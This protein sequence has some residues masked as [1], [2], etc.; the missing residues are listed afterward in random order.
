MKKRNVDSIY[1]LPNQPFPSQKDH[2]PEGEATMREAI[3]SKNRTYQ[4]GMRGSYVYW[5]VQGDTDLVRRAEQ[6]ARYIAEFDLTREEQAS[7]GQS[8][9]QLDERRAQPKPPPKPVDPYW[10]LWGRLKSQNRRSK[11][12]E[13]SDDM[14]AGGG[15]RYKCAVAAQDEV[16]AEEYHLPVTGLSVSYNGEDIVVSAPN[17]SWTSNIVKKIKD[18][19]HAVNFLRKLDTDADYLNRTKGT[20]HA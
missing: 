2:R 11:A 9:A 8:L 19:R 4:V 10:S 16:D 13:E 5:L 7:L 3:R 15:W 12:I 20:E 18:D 14:E 1:T 6:A 17:S